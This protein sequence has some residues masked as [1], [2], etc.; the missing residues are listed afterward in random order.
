M[1][2][3]HSNI[4]KGDFPTAIL[5]LQ[6]FAA[7]ISNSYDV[8]TSQS[9]SLIELRN[10]IEPWLASFKHNSNLLF[11]LSELFKTEKIDKS[12]FLE[13]QSAADQH[14][15]IVYK[16]VIWE[17]MQEIFFYISNQEFFA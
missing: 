10:E 13:L 9:F 4:T 16:D 14:G 8:I 12:K 1:N 3:V 7:E 2:R 6:D 5:L 15:Y 11:S 17:S